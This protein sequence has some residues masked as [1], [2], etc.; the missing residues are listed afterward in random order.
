MG[1]SCKSLGKLKHDFEPFVDRISHKTAESTKH[2]NT[3]DLHNGVRS[4]ENPLSKSYN[5][6][7][8]GECPSHLLMPMPMP[9][10]I[11]I[12]TRNRPA[13]I[14]DN[15]WDMFVSTISF[16]CF[17]I[18]VQGEVDK[19]VWVNTP[20]LG[21]STSDLVSNSIEQVSGR[22]TY[23]KDD[24]SLECAGHFVLTDIGDTSDA[25]S[26]SRW[27]LGVQSCSSQCAKY[28]TEICNDDEVRSNYD[29]ELKLIAFSLR[30]VASNASDDNTSYNENKIT[31]EL[32][33]ADK[34][35]INVW[36]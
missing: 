20:M 30:D 22:S 3:E 29:K 1:N 15:E 21:S 16:E 14:S 6:I 23:S 11:K 13:G 7:G 4:E 33:V 34:V 27:D 17:W 9:E 36:R 32:S 10:F 18:N 35:Q 26:T 5:M 24:S 25:E 12:C 28:Y 31:P 2:N 19:K 8:T